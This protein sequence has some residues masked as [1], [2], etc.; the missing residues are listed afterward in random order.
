MWLISIL[1][2]RRIS[3]SSGTSGSVIGRCPSARRRPRL[4][5]SPS[6]RQ[7]SPAP[8]AARKCSRS[9]AR[10]TRVPCRPGEAARTGRCP[11]RTSCDR[12]RRRDRRAAT[13]E[14]CPWTPTD[15]HHPYDPLRSVASIRRPHVRNGH[16]EHAVYHACIRPANLP[17][18]GK[19]SARTENRRQPS[20]GVEM[21]QELRVDADRLHALVSEYE[22]I[23]EAAK[24]AHEELRAVLAAEG[25]CWGG[26]A[27]GRSFAE[28][29]VPDS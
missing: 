19:V 1:A 4:G 15:S 27:P 28:T 5:V 2:W 23:G 9:R 29:Y 24:R 20:E 7:G 26:D 17:I 13:A 12:V 3:L 10:A 25:D 8:R 21:A 6:P 22:S 14:R 16:P 18:A 11:P